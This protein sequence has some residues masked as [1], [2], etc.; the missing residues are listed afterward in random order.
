MCF[1]TYAGWVYVDPSAH[2]F[3][4]GQS[5]VQENKTFFYRFETKT[6]KEGLPQGIT[7]P[8]NLPRVVNGAI[9]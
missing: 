8:S 9:T 3:N 6:G 7:K 1:N 2:A 4:T 5:S